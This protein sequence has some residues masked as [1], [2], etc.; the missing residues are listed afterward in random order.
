MRWKY[1]KWLIVPSTLITALGLWTSEDAPPDSASAVS[2]SSVTTQRPLLSSVARQHVSLPQASSIIG[3]QW[4]AQTAQPLRDF[5]VWAGRWQRGL[6]TVEEGVV[7]ARSRR[8]YLEKI[9]WSQPN[10]VLEA[11]VPWSVRLALPAP[12][13]AILEER[14]DAIGKLSLLMGTPLPG[15]VQPVGPFQQARVGARGFQIGRAHV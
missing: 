15:N 2:E 9:A 1:I 11:A 14:V 12:I 8:A 6:G 7:L 4:A 5:A 10:V 13:V 3:R